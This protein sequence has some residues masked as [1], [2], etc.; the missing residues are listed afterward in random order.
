MKNK[1]YYGE[2]SLQHWINLILKGNIILPPY[3]RHYAWEEE[4]LIDLKDT[5]T[6]Q[7]F[8][9]PVVIGAFNINGKNTN[10]ILD[11][12]Q[13][14]TS[15][16][17]TYLGIFPK[18]EA[19]KD[20]DFRP[21]A[22]DVE[23]VDDDENN[24]HSVIKWKFDL[25]FIDKETKAIK[26]KTKE[27]ILRDIDKDKY[28]VIE[29]VGLDE[30][31][32]NETFLGFC[33]LVPHLSQDETQQQKYY[34]S[35]F[36]NINIGGKKLSNQESRRSLYFLDKEMIS[37]FEP[38]F[39]KKIH[40]VIANKPAEFDIIK[41]LSLLSDYAKYNYA[42][43]VAR[44]YKSYMEEYYE[45]YV[46]SVVKEND[47][48]FK[49]FIEIFPNKEF[50]GYYDSLEKAINELSLFSFTSIIELD[51]SYFGLFYIFLFEKQEIDMSRK[52]KLELE[53]KTKINEFKEDYSHSHSSGA[54][55]HLRNR[56]ATSIEIYQKY[57]IIN[58]DV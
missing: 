44:G 20:V 12:Q 54:F 31:K 36:R 7:E 8:V 47:P 21:M 46:Y 55:K 2:Y 5:F 49:P 37:F 25:L 32:I 6:N 29:N 41:Y 13:R 16:L 11:G 35:V 50:L 48:K 51:M 1:V 18:K 15:L 43:N 24:A 22:D 45:E 34:S 42:W 17:L 52:S 23:T 58:L 30:Q 38:N 10:L 9:P 19:F 40:V 26:Y 27:E 57:A 56:I 4:D 53:L 3:Q 28:S 33:Y 39:I 14:L